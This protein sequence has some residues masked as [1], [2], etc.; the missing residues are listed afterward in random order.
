MSNFLRFSMARYYSVSPKLFYQ[1]EFYAVVLMQE[2]TTNHANSPGVVWG[3]GTYQCPSIH[4]RDAA[5][6][7]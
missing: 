7:Y 6:R 3:C 5:C 2:Q 4:I 1:T